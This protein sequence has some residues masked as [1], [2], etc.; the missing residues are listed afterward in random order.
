MKSVFKNEKDE[1]AES[2]IVVI[3]KT[4][5]GVCGGTDATLDT[6]APK[7]IACGDMVLFDVT[8]VLPNV[9]K[10][11][12]CDGRVSEPMGYI[13]AFAAP[14]TDGDG[15]FDG[16]FLYI[17][18]GEGF[19]RR[20]GVAERWA[21]V[22]E[23]V[24]SSLTA[25]VNEYDI[26]KNNGCHS[27]THGLPENFGGSVC[28]KYSDGEKISFSDNQ[29]PIIEYEFGC[30]V[31]EVF[32]KAMNGES[33]P[34]PDADA[35]C[36]IRYAQERADGGFIKATLTVNADG[37]GRNVKASRYDSPT[38]YE[39]DKPVSAETVSAIKESIKKTGILAWAHLPDSEY[40]SGGDK[41]LT[42]VF[43]SGDELTVLAGKMLP[44]QIN[45]G[46]FDIELEMT[47]KN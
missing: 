8:S 46:F 11:V 25:L 30:R 15:G 31:A 33:A 17:E 38:V 7:R 20:G 41:K 40:R 32:K 29:S 3:K 42:F 21:F 35:L 16:T 43:K 24:F 34:L 45:G 39:S 6:R 14:A 9:P 37:T 23:N 19:R 2:G 44:K 13:S 10:A 18:T 36:G 4:E 12:I 22:K 26:A 1:S 28:I 27:T 5:P 47:T